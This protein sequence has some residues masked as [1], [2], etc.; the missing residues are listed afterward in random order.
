M[1]AKNPFTASISAR[2]RALRTTSTL[3]RAKGLVAKSAL[4]LVAGSLARHL[5]PHVRNPAP[6]D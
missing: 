2:I 4:T 3:L 1:L 5:A 6:G